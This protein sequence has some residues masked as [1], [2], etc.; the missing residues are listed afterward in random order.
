MWRIAMK[1]RLV[2]FVQGIVPQWAGAHMPTTTEDLRH[3]RKE[4]YGIHCLVI[5]VVA[6]YALS[7]CLIAVLLRYSRV[8]RD[9]MSDALWLWNLCR[10]CA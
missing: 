6:Y 7:L 8:T 1:P 4:D 3:I 10:Y 9:G 2:S 5:S